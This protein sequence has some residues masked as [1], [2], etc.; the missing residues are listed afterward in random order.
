MQEM[1]KASDNLIRVLSHICH[2][3]CKIHLTYFIYIINTN[4][5]FSYIQLIEINHIRL[6]VF[7]SS[8][9]ILKVKPMNIFLIK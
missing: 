6:A 3:F 9:L 1:L 2:N 7:L 5:Y 8:W 4:Q